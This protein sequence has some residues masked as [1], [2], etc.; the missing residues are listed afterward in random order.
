[1]GQAQIRLVPL[2]EAVGLR[3]KEPGV[4]F[5]DAKGEVTVGAH[6]FLT[7]QGP[8]K[9]VLQVEGLTTKQHCFHKDK[10]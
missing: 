9:D 4:S 5:E 10:E 3:Q 1:M 6:K 8:K 2:K 7:I